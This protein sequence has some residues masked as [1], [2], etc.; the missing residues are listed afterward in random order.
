MWLMIGFSESRNGDGTLSS[1]KYNHINF[2]KSND[3]QILRN[4]EGI[5][6]C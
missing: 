6:C 5:T 2:N 1:I 3:Y 4:K